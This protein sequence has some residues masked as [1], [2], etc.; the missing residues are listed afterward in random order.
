MVDDPDVCD[1]IR[2]L[3]ERELVH[4]QRF[5]EAEQSIWNDHDGVTE[6]PLKTKGNL[7]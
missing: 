3:R 4:Y 6:K 1:A 5:G 7:T 2:F